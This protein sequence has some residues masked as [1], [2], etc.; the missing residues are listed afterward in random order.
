VTHRSPPHRRGAADGGPQLGSGHPQVVK[1]SKRATSRLTCSLAAAFP[2][3]I[4]RDTVLVSYNRRRTAAQ[5][6]TVA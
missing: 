2:A 3:L 4:L 5:V 6:N 1:R